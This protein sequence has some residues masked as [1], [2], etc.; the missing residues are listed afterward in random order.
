MKPDKCIKQIPVP[1][2]LPYLVLMKTS[3]CFLQNMSTFRTIKPVSFRE[4]DKKRL[5]PRKTHLC[6]E[7]QK[8][9]GV[10][11]SLQKKR[12]I[13][14]WHVCREANY[15]VARDRTLTPNLIA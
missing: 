2:E 7:E 11:I 4:D 6:N 1:F 5:I 3:H 15:F 12:G 13:V 9:Y 10:D 8:S 14:C